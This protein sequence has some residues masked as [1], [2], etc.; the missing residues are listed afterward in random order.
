MALKIKKVSEGLYM[1][2]LTRPDVP[3]A[4]AKWS[5]PEP[6]N[7]DQMIQE[8]LNRGAHQTDRTGTRERSHFGRLSKSGGAVSGWTALGRSEGAGGF[9]LP[10][11][12]IF[13]NPLIY[14][15]LGLNMPC[16]R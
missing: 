4:T 16:C 1:A 2:K 13:C 12:N 10:P 3:A 7:V 8:L 5:S 9:F 14:I 11:A 6:L 15:H